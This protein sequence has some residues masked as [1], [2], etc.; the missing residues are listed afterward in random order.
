MASSG[1]EGFAKTKALRPDLILLDLIMPGMDGLEFLTRLRSDLAPPI[2][3]AILCSGFE[4]TEEE[5][6]RR[7]ALMFVR[8]PVTPAD[9]CEFVALGLHRRA[10]QRGDGRSGARELGG[11]SHASAKDGRHFRRANPAGSR[12]EGGRSNGM[13]GRVLRRR[14]SSDI[15]HGGAVA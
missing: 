4:L 10:G 6:L 1:E 7:G 14:D 15:S 2:P 11:R 12:A 8:K 5:A 9:L 13:A 3:P